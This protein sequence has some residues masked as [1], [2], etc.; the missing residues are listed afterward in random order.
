MCNCNQSRAA[1]TAT[2]SREKS[3]SVRVKLVKELPITLFGTFTGR[4]YKFSNLNDENAI[5][6]R[7]LQAIDG[8][9]Q[10]EIVG[11]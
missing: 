3:G 10:L 9:P 6:G 11:R 7:D 8:L 4:M 2:Y 1:H 5:D